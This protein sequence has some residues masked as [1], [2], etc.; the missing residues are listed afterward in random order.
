[1][2]IIRSFLFVPANRPT[3]IE[4]IPGY[5][6]DAVILDLEDSVTE[7]DKG[8]ARDV[9]NRSIAGLAASGQRVYV[10]INRSAHMFN[11]EDIVAV[12][13]PGLEGLILPKPESAEDVGI[14]AALVSEAES[15]RDIKAGQTALV[16]VLETARSVV[17]AYNIAQHPRVTAVVGASAKNGDVSRSLGFQW[18]EKG[19]ETLYMRS[20]VVAAARAAGKAPIGGLWQEVH[21][22]EGLARW[23]KF[24]RQLGFSG[25]LVLHPSNVTVVNDAYTPSADEVAYYIAM[26]DAFDVARAAG[27]GAVTFQGEHIDNAHVT[28]ARSIVALAQSVRSQ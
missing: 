8:A 20:S 13:Q 2:T 27:R 6:A 3:W 24:N 22:L 5:G 7:T 16:P 11:F 25:E 17:E 15:R 10:R 28:T 18:T 4:K 21:D 23:A 1:M 12:V 9:A 19:L 26:I 14:A